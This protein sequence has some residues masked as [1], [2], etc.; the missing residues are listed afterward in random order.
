[1]YYTLQ[2]ITSDHENNLHLRKRNSMQI[3]TVTTCIQLETTFKNMPNVKTCI[4]RCF[5]H[6]ELIYH[7]SLS[8]SSIEHLTF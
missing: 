1:M 2:V 4:D 7:R 6:I 8:I 3:I 5:Y